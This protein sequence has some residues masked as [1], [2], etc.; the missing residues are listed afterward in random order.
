MTLDREVARNAA[1]KINSGYT[2]MFSQRNAKDLRIY[3]V[4]HESSL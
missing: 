4:D 1:G 3:S 2:V